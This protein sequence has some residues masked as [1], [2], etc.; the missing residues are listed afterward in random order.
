MTNSNRPLALALFF[1]ILIGCA[2][3][4]VTQIATAGAQQWPEE[5]EFRE[6]VA[7]SLGFDG[8]LRDLPSNAKPIYGWRPVGGFD[9]GVILCR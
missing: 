7:Y 4:Q 9:S 8:S 3:S 2:S 6:C 1:G 5:G